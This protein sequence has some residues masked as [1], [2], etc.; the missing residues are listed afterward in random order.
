V[1]G[2]HEGSFTKRK[3]S[4]WMGRIQLDG[5]KHCVYGTTRSEA[6]EKIQELVRR[7]ESGAQVKPQNYTV[8]EWSEFWLNNYLKTK[9][10]P[11]SYLQQVSIVEKHIVPEV[12]EVTLQKLSFVDVQTVVRKKLES[13]LSSAMVQKIRNTLHAIIQ[14]AVDTGLLIKNCVKLVCVKQTKSK[15]IQTLSREQLRQLITTTKGHPFYPALLLLATT[16]LRRSELC[17]LK[18]SDINWQQKTLLIQRAVVKL[19]GYGISVQDTKT[20]SSRRLLPITPPTLESLRIHQLQHPD[21][22]YVFS[23][24][25]GQPLYPDVIYDHLKRIGKRLG[26]PHVTVHMLRHTVA[27]L[28]LE[29]GEHPKVV[30]ELLGHS[31]IGITMDIY[32]HV[33]PGMKH[34]AVNKL[35]EMLSVV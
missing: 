11:N 5:Q 19:G 35:T 13:G 1:R 2:K 17:G 29:A 22:E 30:Q 25:N 32:S 4:S 8:K 20:N 24:A 7:F 23:R 28:L 15:E 9:V 10:R 6:Q 16:G 31:S 14:Y 33:M 27:S 18:W 12:G 21:T 3:D 34:Q 26:F